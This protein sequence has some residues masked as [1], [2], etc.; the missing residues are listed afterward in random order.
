MKTRGVYEY[1]DAFAAGGDR[2]QPDGWVVDRHTSRAHRHGWV[3]AGA[4]H[5]LCRGNKH[6]PLTPP[7]K[8]FVLTVEC[9]GDA[10][11]SGAG[12]YVFLRYDPETG[13]GYY[14]KR[15]W[16][17]A[18]AE[19]HW[20]SC[21]REG[22][23]LLAVRKDAR[24]PAGRPL[25]D[26]TAL[27]IEVR[28]KTV[29][30]CQDGV[31]VAVFQEPGLR[32]APAGAVAFD[33]DRPTLAGA[34]GPFFLR[35]VCLRAEGAPPPKRLWAPCRIAFP[36]EHNGI[37]SPIYYHLEAVAYAGHCE[38][39]ARL[40][41]GP[42]DRRDPALL[43]D[44]VK[45][46]LRWQN[47]RLV[48]PYVRFERPGGGEL[49]TF[50]LCR[51]AV[52]L[53]TQWNRFAPGLPPADA[54]FPLERVIR[55]PPLPASVN[56]FVGYDDYEA[57]ERQWMKGGPT[58]AW[59]VP[60][61]GTVLASGAR[62][63][64][65]D[66]DL[67]IQSPPDKAMVRRIPANEPRRAQA[68]A[69]ARAN[70]Y[71]LDRERVR[72]SI[73]LRHRLADTAAGDLAVDWTLEDAFRQP[74]ARARA[75]P[76]R[77]ARDAEARR[78]AQRRGVPTLLGGALPGPLPVGVYHLAA[79][80]RRNGRL[81]AET[82]RA[83][84]VLSPDPAVPAPPRASGLPDLLFYESSDFHSAA[85]VFDPWTGRNVDEG[86]YVSHAGFPAGFAARHRAWSLVRRY[87]RRWWCWLICGGADL[88]THPEAVRQADLIYSSTLIQRFD[89][90]QPHAYRRPPA[91]TRGP[92][93]LDA[94]LAFLER[95]DSPARGDARLDAEAIRRDGALSEAG[96][97]A[98]TE[99]YWKPWLEWFNRWYAR[100]YM[101]QA[102]ARL[103]ALKFRGQWGWF[104]P[105]P[106]Y[107]SVYKS[108]WFP[109]LMGRDLRSGWTRYVNGP[110]RFESYPIV[111]GYPI[112]RDVFQLAAMKM[113]A[114]DLRLYPE[115]Y[116][117]TGIPAD[118]H[119]VLGSPPFARAAPP[120]ACYRKRFFEYAYAAA[121][122]DGAG[123]RFWNDNG[124]QP[125]HWGRDEFSEFLSAWSVIRRVRPRRPLRTA[126]FVYSR[127]ACRRHPDTIERY[128]PRYYQDGKRPVFGGDIVNTAEEGVAFAY[129]QARA[130]G[131]AAGFLVDWAH[132]ARLSP[133]DCHTL[134]LP[135]LTGLTE[136]ERRLLRRLH[137]RGVNLLALERA[138][139]LEDLFGVAP[140]A[141]PLTL[142]A[143]RVHAAAARRVPWSELQN[144]PES[145][146]HDLCRAAYG[147][148][149][150]VPILEGLDARGRRAPALTLHRT[151][152]GWTA[153]F[154]IAPTL[155][156]RESGDATITYGKASL[157][158]LVNRAMALVL[159]AIGKPPVETT[160]G[161]LITFEDTRG[162][163]RIVIM[164]D[165]HPEPA[166]PIEPVITLRL[167][168]LT[169][170]RVACD[171]P[172]E[173]V[174]CRPSGLRLR[175]PLPPH[176]CAMLAVRR[177]RR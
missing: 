25:E 70:H 151:R 163:V 95:P 5:I 82:R 26:W 40:T 10:G 13:A 99:Q 96:F 93:A 134:V 114:P 71:F 110:M 11:A 2:E 91:P 105:Y 4:Y 168:G 46:N 56:V 31:E 161:K 104:G 22:D 149:G 112:Q 12:V 83:F 61:R 23:R 20:G 142:R 119:V 167:P 103:R 64:P 44:S 54:D 176:A 152:W 39:T 52:G 116:G 60:K 141:A 55:L 128:A 76:L 8:D 159:R 16:G 133:G 45:T 38:I 102:Q 139:G 153:L 7:L 92:D 131:Q 47:E 63:A 51:G 145:I 65:G 17:A 88:E 171:R 165:H 172:F 94:L 36:A 81:L 50:Y 146:S 87:R 24:P 57:E 138:D 169:P 3:E 18:G 173:V 97:R 41:G 109:H 120:P 66:L 32:R 85:D 130:D 132:L 113:E 177:P 34:R 107:G 35:N 101:P 155:V 143:L 6:R 170:D 129:E 147:C 19:T 79:R 115:V 108:A 74:M 175:V 86:H 14:V 49:G 77:E 90:W 78:W 67:D 140:L 48:N 156:R 27:R 121:W 15:L 118:L 28:G 72:F 111:C 98:L 73:R 135:P 59:I 75:C 174:A 154:A 126:A 80:L 69:F 166:V 144:N 127:E 157:S 53:K 137:A 122:F 37:V 29:T 148:R 125:K 100:T 58:E 162:T 84:E 123:F 30:V 160:A 89:L 62:L 21:R 117:L 124:F 150:A 9:R 158:R 1:R 106:P 68:V 164:E 43:P 42:A 33:R 136:A